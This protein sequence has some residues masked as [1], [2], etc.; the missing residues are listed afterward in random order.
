MSRSGKLP[1]LDPR[2]IGERVSS[3]LADAARADS[4]T[5]ELPRPDEEDMSLSRS[6][7]KDCVP[8]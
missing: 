3:E 4:I 5:A 7:A 1:R 8:V 6:D 2:S